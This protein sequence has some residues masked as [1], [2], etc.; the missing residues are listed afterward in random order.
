MRKK[1]KSLI[2]IITDVYIIIYRCFFRSVIGLKHV[3]LH[4][5]E[6]RTRTRTYTRVRAD[7]YASHE[8]IRDRDVDVV[9]VSQ[10]SNPIPGRRPRIISVIGVLAMQ[11]RNIGRL[12]R[13]DERMRIVYIHVHVHTCMRARTHPAGRGDRHHTT[14]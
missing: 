9:D 5:R 10:R 14:N 11:L 6:T 3:L 1:K 7:A 13:D 4:G 8:Y 2:Y 12:A